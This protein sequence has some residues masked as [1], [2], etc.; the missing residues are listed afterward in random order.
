MFGL[1]GPE[2]CDSICQ[3]SLFILAFL[4]QKD[5]VIEKI[6]KFENLYD[7]LDALLLRDNV[8]MKTNIVEILA[9]LSKQRE[10]ASKIISEITHFNALEEIRPGNNHYRVLEK[11]L[12]NL[13]KNSDKS[14]PNSLN[15]VE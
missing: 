15:M 2:T 13:T 1:L 11:N 10:N 5:E 14:L 3:Q 7:V 9:W 12:M 6:S 4:S 8:K